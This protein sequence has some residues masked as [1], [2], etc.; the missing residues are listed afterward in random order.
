[1]IAGNS[2]RP[3]G[4]CG[5]PSGVVSRSIH[6]RHTTQEEDVISNWMLTA[7]H[8][9][10]VCPRHKDEL[11]SALYTTT[12]GSSWGMLR[13]ESTDNYTRQKVNYRSARPQWYADAWVVD[14]AQVRRSP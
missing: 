13:P 10:Q 8:N 11:M 9:N 4:A 3:G 2:G 6:A 7:A 12:I 5:S 14:D 1:M